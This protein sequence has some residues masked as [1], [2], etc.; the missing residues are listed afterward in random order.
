[1]SYQ[2]LARKWRP[3][4]FHEMVGQEH[5]L[6]ALINALDTNRLHHAYLFTGTRGVGKTTL[7]R[8]LA[9]CLNCEQGVSSQPCEQCASCLEV[10][11]GRCV[12]LLEIDA[13]SRTRV[14][15]TREILD[16]VQYA[17]TRARYKVYLI[18]E[19]HMLSTHSFNALLKTL[20]EPPP[21]VKFLLATTDPQKLPA[22]VLSRCLQF[23]LKNMQP[24]QIVSHL[25]HVLEQEHVTAEEPALWLLGRA[26]Q[27]SMRDALSLTDQAIA[28]GSGQLLENDV[29]AMLGTVDMTFVYQLLE[30]LADGQPAP[31]LDVVKRM[32]EHAPDFSGSLDELISLLHRVTLAQILPDAIDNSWGDAERVS[33]L[34]GRFSAEDVQLFYQIAI[35]GKRD[36]PMAADVRCGFEM[37]LLRMLA[38]R[39]AA[40]LDDSIS[41]DQLQEQTAVNPTVGAEDHSLKKSESGKSGAAFAAPQPEVDN[42]PQQT[43][44]STAGEAV[45]E[46]L[47]ETAAKAFD[48]EPGEVAGEVADRGAAE[49]NTEALQERAPEKPPS[50]PPTTE[51]VDTL[52][53]PPEPAQECSAEPYSC[54]PTQ[55]VE[56]TPPP[57][58]S[59]APEQTQDHG[60][61][62]V[63]SV[64]EAPAPDPVRDNSEQQ[65]VLSANDSIHT[66]AQELPTPQ[67]LSLN[68]GRDWPPVLAQLG[69]RGMLYNTASHCALESVD[70]HHYHF[71]LDENHAALYRED[72]NEQIAQAISRLMNNTAQVTITVGQPQVITPAQDIEAKRQARQAQAVASIENDSALQQFIEQFEGKLEPDSIAP[73]EKGETG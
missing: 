49:P 71:T 23:N 51:S 8:L 53:L 65:P 50:P 67:P 13:A 46:I 68:T 43:P 64:V 57:S 21:H 61:A 56:T 5:V 28:F 55:Q 72:H 62:A 52:S 30:H 37:V 25:G 44:E 36:L 1:M 2:V 24:Q 4:S 70:N 29:R 69:L 9:K 3:R 10:A 38:F 40:V 42:R 32:S 19:V 31:L 11:E 27:G 26:A 20:E 12:D 34:A 47:P 73:I 66:P 33:A 14:E 58:V 17:P 6:K 54:A 16:N 22:T 48:K 59:S 39:P 15:D 18:D 45:L 35:N 41:P 63:L 60:S 7:A